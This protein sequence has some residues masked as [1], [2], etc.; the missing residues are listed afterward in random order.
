[1]GRGL[2]AA[3]LAVLIWGAQLP[4]AKGAF[5]ALDSY[6]M[7][8]VR[9]APALVAF[10]FALLW[11]EGRQSYSV[12]SGRQLLRVILAGMAMGGSA[13]LMFIGLS[14]TRPEIAVLILGLQ[15][16]LTVL[17]DWLVW[18][19]RPPAFTL[20][21]VAVAFLG[22]AVAVT[23]GGDLLLHP[24]PAVRGEVFGNILVLGAAL[25]WVTY[26]LL[27]TRLHGWSTIRVSAL[28]TGPAVAVV[29][30]FWTVANQLGLTYVDWALLPAAT[31]RLAYVSLIGVI[32]A[33][34]LWNSG[35]GLIGAVNAMLLVNL[36]PIITFAFRA[37]EGVSFAVSEIAGAAMVVGALVAN[38]L[39]LRR[40]F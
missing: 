24:A 20:G 39:F 15:P 29:L 22:V 36:M 8:V 21:C 17:A 6:S 33:M 31:W 26:V 2:G 12:A 19:R 9:Y 35:A 34:F 25:L 11:I 14:K 40:R 7:T 38:N 28:T 4:I 32:V 23:Q 18:H 10:G 37:F 13:S 27:S 3:L 16:A 1:M 30:L 5:G